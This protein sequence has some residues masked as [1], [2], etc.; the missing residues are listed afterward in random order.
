[1]NDLLNKNKI[2]SEMLC[3]PSYSIQTETVTGADPTQR[4]E[5]AVSDRPSTAPGN[6]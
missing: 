6:G 1:M 4:N 3:L 2:H 5:E